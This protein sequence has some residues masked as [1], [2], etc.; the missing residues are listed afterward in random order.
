MFVVQRHFEGH[1]QAVSAW[2]AFDA[3]CYVCSGQSYLYDMNYRVLE[4][5]GVWSSVVYECCFIDISNKVNWK[6]EGF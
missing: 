3:A 6:L 5:D 4:T 2:H 1:W